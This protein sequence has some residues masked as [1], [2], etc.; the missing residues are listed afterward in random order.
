MLSIMVCA[1]SVAINIAVLI[2][3]INWWNITAGMICS[4]CLWACIA[5]RIVRD[6]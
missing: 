4:G 1:F 5:L 3:S 2:E 6:W